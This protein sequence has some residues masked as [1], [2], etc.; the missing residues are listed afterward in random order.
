MLLKRARLIPR[1]ITLP[2]SGAGTVAP[3]LP[4]TRRFANNL[5]LRSGVETPDHFRRGC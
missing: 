3:P 4:N 5:W 2:G 1:G